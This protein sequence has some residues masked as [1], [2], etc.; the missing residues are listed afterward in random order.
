[1]GSAHPLMTLA[2]EKLEYEECALLC[3][4]MTLCRLHGK[5]R[6]HPS[7]VSF[8]SHACRTA[9]RV[10]MLSENA[11]LA[12]AALLQH[13]PPPLSA[14]HLPTQLRQHYRE[15]A[16]IL[17][18]LQL[19]EQI[20]LS[21][22]QKSTESRRTMLL[23][24]TSG[25]RVFLLTACNRWTDLE[26][27]QTPHRTFMARTVL[28]VHAPLATRLGMY[29]LKYGLEAVAFPLLH[30]EEART[31]AIQVGT[32]H[33]DK[34]E[35]LH[36]GAQQLEDICRSAGIPA[37]VHSREK[38]P[39]SI[40]RK[41]ME[42]GTTS[43]RDL[44]DIFAMRILVGSIEE[45]YLTLGVIHQHFRPL[46]HRFHDY[47]A[48]PK[49][50][51]Y[52]SLHT[53]IM[54]LD[55]RQPHL[56]VEVQIR[57][58]EIH[59]EAEYGIAAHWAY[60]EQWTLESEEGGK[61]Q[62]VLAIL[63]EELRLL[64]DSTPGESS[65]PSSDVFSDRIYTLTP[66]GDVVELPSGS[67]PLDFAFHIHTDIGM[68]FRAARV[69]GMIVPIDHVLENGDVVE[70]LTQKEPHPSL[71]W[72]RIV[73]TNEARSKLRSHLSL[74]E[75]DHFVE[76]GRSLL[77]DALRRRHLPPLD[78][79]CTLLRNV[80]GQVLD[81]TAR[82]DFLAK[83]GQ[84]AERASSV[85]RHLGLALTQTKEATA[86]P[87]SSE[88]RTI[89][90]PQGIAMPFRFAGCCHPEEGEGTP[91]VGI[92]TRR[93]LLS[94]HHRDCHTLKAANPQRLLPVSWQRR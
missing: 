35:F 2:E 12:A 31:I 13:L 73:R 9:E 4:A 21:Q 87:P 23:A 39:Y 52:R 82:E 79:N 48:F 89:E 53:T 61:W 44:P 41:L 65:P 74:C 68:R 94:I 11:V 22:T 92:V 63:R 46:L 55:P 37:I 54:E 72:V 70:V 17:K 14:Q 1:M 36:E 67:T 45:C 80:H 75:R 16:A 49:P 8:F 29:T 50:N 56:A 3:E 69:N 10:L 62:R 71:H 51:G 33:E 60:K 24:L 28:D 7:G 78:A 59:H 91:L 42:R 58:H 32:L 90:L 57:T 27:E 30:P 66:H 15:F 40:F 77:N 18:R 6:Q 85:L 84:G 34:E 93:G 20:G 26:A 25:A 88:G 38:H 43:V 19:V 47:I 76:Q 83:I 86:A 5:G 81:M 64:A